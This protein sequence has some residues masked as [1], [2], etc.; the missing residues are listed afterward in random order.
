MATQTDKIIVDG[1]KLGGLIRSFDWASTSLGAISSW[2]QS[3]VTSVNIVLESSVPMVML[4]GKDGVM[5]YNDAYSKFAGAR[6]PKLLGSKVLKGWPEVADFNRNVMKVVL[7]GKTLSYKDQELTLYRNNIPEQ[8]WMNLNY[9][10]IIDESGKPV[11]VLAIVVETTQRIIAQRNKRTAER[12]LKNER[13]RLHSLLMDAPAC[14]ALV[15]GPEHVFEL[16]NPRYLELLGNRAIIGKTVR[17]A[18]PEFEGQGVYENL[19]EVYKTGK[20]F[21][22]NEV[23]VQFDRTGKGDIYTGYFNFVYQPTYDAD[24]KVD[25]I[26]A[27]GLDVTEQVES[28]KKVEEI[29]ILNK[30][31]TDN[32]ATGLLIIDKNHRCNFMNPAAER[33]TGYSFAD[34][35]AIDAP[36]H[37]LIHNKKPDGSPFPVSDCPIHHAILQQDQTSGEDRFVRKDGTFYPVAYSTRRIVQDGMTV[38]TVMEIRDLTE[39]KHAIEEQ[40]RLIKLTNQRNELLLLNKAKDEFISLASHQLRTPATAVKQYISLVMNEYM[41]PISDDQLQYLQTA[42]NSNERQLRIINDLLKTA[43]IDSSRYVLSKKKMG[44]AK[45]VE[46]AIDDME[47]VLEIKKQTVQF[48]NEAGDTQVKVD[49]NEMC[50][51]FTNLLENASKYSY[52]G[53]EIRIRLYK[54]AKYVHISVKDKGVGIEKK[55][56][57]RIFEKFTRID[58]ELSDTV[59]GTGLGLY[60]VKRIVKLHEG[61]IEVISEPGKGSE[62][63]VSLPHA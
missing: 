8:V 34:I 51:V 10:P 6:H 21:Y 44:P 41:G 28:R 23:P 11:G 39:E 62:F 46:C 27:Y 25:G 63:I 48:D 58:N 4:W 61:A 13:S 7:S 56:I 18:I 53:S 12:E 57:K 20:P 19:D 55:S 1:G 30:T 47:S 60:W 3:L 9:S 32:T 35:S 45:L 33:I 17:E 43:Q 59:T 38:G 26:Y 14:I 40:R 5:L 16:A 37:D 15:R 54:T 31:I 29:A 52:P 36:L 2:P 50:L 24:K 22:G 49:E 42:Y